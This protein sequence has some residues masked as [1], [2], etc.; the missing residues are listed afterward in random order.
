M[1]GK[2]IVISDCWAKQVVALIV[3]FWN[4]PSPPVGSSLRADSKFKIPNPICFRLLAQLA[5]RADSRAALTAGSNSAINTPMM[6]ITTSNSTN[7]KPR[8][9]RELSQAL[10]YRLLE[11]TKNWLHE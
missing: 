10:I 4:V 3:A 2:I 7:V 1:Y 8:R 9:A 11:G 5:R 6:E